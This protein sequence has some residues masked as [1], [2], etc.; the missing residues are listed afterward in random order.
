MKIIINAE[1]FGLSKSINK[2]IAEGLEKGFL[3]SASLF[4]NGSFVDEAVNMIKQ[5]GF[6]N[7]GVH[8]NL[9]YGTPTAEKA[10]VKHLLEPDGKFHYMC[11]MPFYAKY[12]E[13]KIELE[14]QIK[15]FLSFGITPSHL[16]FHH[17]FYSSKEVYDAYL[18]LAK[19]YSLPVRSMTPKTAELAKKK[20]V[21]TTDF[22]VEDFHASPLKSAHTLEQIANF[23]KNKNGSAEIMTVP[24]YLDQ[25]TMTQT[26]YL[27]RED[28]LQ[29][30]K[31]AFENNVWQ[32]FELC[33]FN[34][35]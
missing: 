2:G 34:D 12:A 7:V 23:F 25:F 17:Y 1:D 33:S 15:K 13:V 21:K 19:K 5:N 29:A 20:G 9:T 32:D 26:N 30:L 8:L 28:E 16:D 11:S 6:K 3:T 14:A 18:D 31:E 35:L 10:K 4:V 24:G 22:F 27:A